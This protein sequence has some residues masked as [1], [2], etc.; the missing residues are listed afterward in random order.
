MENVRE[1]GR[2][3]WFNGTFGFVS[4]EGNDEGVFVHQSSIRMP[5]YR[6]LIQGEE[7]TFELQQTEKGVA[8]V[9][10][11]PARFAEVATK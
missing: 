10:V 7:L 9:N 8:A 11:V 5:G 2:C 1:K 6:A 4:Y 3:K